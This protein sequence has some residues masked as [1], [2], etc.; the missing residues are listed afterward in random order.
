MLFTVEGR[1]EGKLVFSCTRTRADSFLLVWWK[2]GVERN[3]VSLPH[4]PEPIVL[5][6]V[7]GWRETGLFSHMHRR[8]KYFCIEIGKGGI[9]RCSSRTC[10]IDVNYGDVYGTSC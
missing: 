2:G 10:V 8:L 1:G 3:G 4:A 7:A 9:E 6:M 5:S